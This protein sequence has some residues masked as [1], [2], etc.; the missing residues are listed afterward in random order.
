MMTKRLLLSQKRGPALIRRG[1]SAYRPPRACRSARIDANGH[2]RASSIEDPV[3][4][5]AVKFF[6]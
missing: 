5:H 1:L 6:R 2:P 4:E 3:H